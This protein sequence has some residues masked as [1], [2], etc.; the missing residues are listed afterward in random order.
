MV[1]RFKHY[2]GFRSVP[3]DHTPGQRTSFAS[4]IGEVMTD[5]GI[6]I[7]ELASAAEV[8]YEMARRYITGGAIPTYARVKRIADWLHMPVEW[9]MFGEGSNEAEQLSRS[10]PFYTLGDEVISLDSA[11]WKGRTIPCAD[12][13]VLAAVEISYTMGC[14]R[15][16]DAGLSVLK[17]GDVV[18]VGQPAED[19]SPDSRVLIRLKGKDAVRRHLIRRVA[20]A[21]DMT[22]TYAA[23]DGE[24]FPS[25]PAKQA[26]VVG[27]VIG[28]FVKM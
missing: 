22:V 27:A 17:K 7:Q 23:E 18:F 26:D 16:V 9:L 21:P 24:R 20:F 1:N 3:K 14:E 25:I 8:S 13:N 11:Q 15:R 4:R 19:P 5:R 2:K 28:V 10:V 6:E 12:T